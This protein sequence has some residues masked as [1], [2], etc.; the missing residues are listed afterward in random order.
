[1][2]PTQTLFDVGANMGQYSLYAAYRGIDVHAFEP[3]SQN[4]ALLCRNIAI[5]N[6]GYKITPWPIALMDEVSIDKFYVQSLTVGGSCSSYG[7][8]VNYHLQPKKFPIH[9]GSMSYTLDDFSDRYGMPDH[10][11]I[12]V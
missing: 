2:T 12:D 4:F 6:L 3:E 1:M 11:K 5:N 10:I 7:K 9:Q 8:E